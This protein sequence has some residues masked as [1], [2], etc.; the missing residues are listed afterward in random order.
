MPV[1]FA[2]RPHPRIIARTN[3]GPPTAVVVT[4]ADTEA[5]FH[6]V[7]QLQAHL[8]LQDDVINELLRSVRQE[9]GAQRS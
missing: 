9:G 3:E 2:H 5:I 8:Q 6:E 1:N 4:F 7:G